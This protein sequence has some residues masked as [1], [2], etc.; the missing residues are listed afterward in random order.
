[1]SS[2]TLA[3]GDFTLLLTMQRTTKK[4]AV[5]L[6]ELA[7]PAG[8]SRAAVLVV[9]VEGPQCVRVTGAGQ[10]RRMAMVLVGLALRRPAVR[11]RLGVASVELHGLT[12]DVVAA[13][14]SFD[15]LSSNTTANGTV[16]TTANTTA[17]PIVTNVTGVANTSAA[18]TAAAAT[19]A[20][21]T[22]AVAPT[23][24]PSTAA[25]VQ[26]PHAVSDTAPGDGHA[27]CNRCMSDCASDGCATWCWSG[28]YMAFFV[29]PVALSGGLTLAILGAAYC[30]KERFQCSHNLAGRMWMVA[31]LCA[32]GIPQLIVQYF[33]MFHRDAMSEG[34]RIPPCIGSE[35]SIGLWGS[36]YNNV[37]T[38]DF[39]ATCT[40][41]SGL[42]LIQGMRVA[43]MLAL[44]SAL[45]ASFCLVA[46]PSAIPGFALVGA[47]I[48]GLVVTA[49]LAET[50]FTTD[51]FCHSGRSLEA[52]LFHKSAAVGATYAAIAFT[53]AA[54]L[55]TA[56][57]R[58]CWPDSF[59]PV[60][61]P[62]GGQHEPEEPTP[63]EGR[64]V[65]TNPDAPMADQQPLDTG[66]LQ[67]APEQPVVGVPVS[68]P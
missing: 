46:L 50:L 24:P 59:E 16:F 65:D 40:G 6:A 56:F 18:A 63:V 45:V 1:V 20:A 35:V 54:V 12:V 51:D 32:G 44:F 52:L 2:N 48:V 68:T 28:L 38:G 34:E 11:E 27:W 53:G 57:I 33:A 47:H 64:P 60:P 25:E 66:A 23:L 29:V 14:R 49:V 67:D 37:P 43:S 5:H 31:G 4:L 55:A 9:T 3:S 41:N 39:L 8:D 10:Q 42:G 21:V 30:L 61:S 58:C 13:R 19:A 7:E 36:G 15:A 26:P 17:T 62:A 22:T